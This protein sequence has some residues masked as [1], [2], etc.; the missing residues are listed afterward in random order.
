[1]CATTAECEALQLCTSEVELAA[2]ARQHFCLDREVLSDYCGGHDARR[3]SDP[4]D[5][6][7]SWAGAS[8]GDLCITARELR[9]LCRTELGR[10]AFPCDAL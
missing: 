10:E 8:D 3:C 5:L 9:C 6:C 7:L 2:G 1:M 4:S